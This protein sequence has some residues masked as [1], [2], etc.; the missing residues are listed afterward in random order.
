MPLSMYQASVPV[1]N[2]MLANLIAILNR[3]ANHCESRKIDPAALINYRLYPDMFTFAKQVQLACDHAGNAAS[4][5]AG[6]EMPKAANA[7]QSF[8]ELI[9]RVRGTLA[10]LQTFKPEQ[11]D[12]S[13]ERQVVIIRG[14]TVNTYSGQDYLL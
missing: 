7:E 13:D 11:I 1:L 6:I 14:E 8:E 3:A 4:R 2:R 12:G 5:L 10:Y 9:E